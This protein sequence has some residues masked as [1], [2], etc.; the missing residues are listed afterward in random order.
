[1]YFTNI[2]HTSYG[3]ENNIRNNL[4]TEELHFKHLKNS[5]LILIAKTTANRL[6][7]MEDQNHQ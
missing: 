6:T 7:R 4:T 1:M 2:L 3:V 5:Y